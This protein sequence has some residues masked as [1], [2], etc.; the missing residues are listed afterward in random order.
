MQRVCVGEMEMEMSFFLSVYGS[1][2]GPEHAIGLWEPGSR[3]VGSGV[4]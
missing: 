1:H 3:A 2:A 4:P